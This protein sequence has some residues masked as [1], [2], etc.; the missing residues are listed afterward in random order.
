VRL[1]AALPQPFYAK[2]GLWLP[3]GAAI[4]VLIVG[5]AARKT[6]RSRNCV[7]IYTI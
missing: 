3:G 2:A 4:L 5:F 1:P 7:N 6:R